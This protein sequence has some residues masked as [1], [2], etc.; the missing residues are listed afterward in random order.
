MAGVDEIERIRASLGQLK[1]RDSISGWL[2]GQLW[3]KLR[4]FPRDL[5][6]RIRRSLKKRQQV[7]N[8]SAFTRELQHQHLQQVQVSQGEAEMP[9]VA[10][11]DFFVSDAMKGLIAKALVIEPGIAEIR[12]D[13][14]AMRLPQGDVDFLYFKAA[15]AAI[16]ARAYD[17]VVLMPAGRMGGADLV[18]GILSTTL[19]QSGKVLILRT[20][21]SH[22]D[23]PQWFPETADTVDL[24]KHFNSMKNKT[25]GLYLILAHIAAPRIFNVNSRLA[26]ETTVEFGRQLSAHAKLYA[27]FFCSDRS[28][29]G[30][31]TG[32]P[33]IFFQN[34]FAHLTAAMLDTVYLAEV[35]RNRFCI[36][37]AEAVKLKTVYTPAQVDFSQTPVPL[38]QPAGPVRQ[39]PCILWGGRLDRQK[40]FDLVQKIARA[41]PDVDFLCW[42]KAVLDKA[43]SKF[44]MPDN[45]KLRP[46]FKSYD[47]LP[48]ADCDGWL[49]TS[50][51][52]GLPTIL[53][54]LGALGMPVVASAVGG[55]GE[56]ITPQTGWPVPETASVEDYV[57]SLRE[58]INDPEARAARG[59]ALRERVQKQHAMPA[60]ASLIDTI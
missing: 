15:L 46:P 41:M 50:E 21:D 59:M 33:V 13:E 39:R 16:P 11:A 17:A 60:F 8:Q 24:S 36:P 37:P 3:R 43:P 32:Y 2:L 58:M 22:W 52:D 51:W 47:D 9:S 19:S 49:Y 44:G 5:S 42:G 34:T 1:S 25:R 10:R 56:L 40:R 48:L 57:A 12:G 26:F 7:S 30:V 29:A 18:A 4:H 31:E 35:L 28:E 53:I 6:R 14:P 55:V 27:Y 54:E 23:Y 38:R 45:L 20:D